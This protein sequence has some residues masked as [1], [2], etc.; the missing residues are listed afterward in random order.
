MAYRLLKK[1]G[2]KMDMT[3]RDFVRV[4][5]LVIKGLNMVEGHKIAEKYA[6]SLRGG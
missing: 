4:C 2:Y 5:L 3:E 1:H 6:R